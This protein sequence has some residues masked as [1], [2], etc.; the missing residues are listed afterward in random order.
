V[1]API[2]TISSSSDGRD[3]ASWEQTYGEES[4]ANVLGD[5]TLSIDEIFAF[6]KPHQ[7]AEAET[8]YRPKSNAKRNFVCDT[9]NTVS[10]N[11]FMSAHTAK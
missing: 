2:Q 10:I 7:M 6:T 8:Q 3:R 9:V 5:I 1:V 11:K 4:Q